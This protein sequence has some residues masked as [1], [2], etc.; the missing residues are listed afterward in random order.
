MCIGSAEER[1]RLT[2]IYGLVESW[3]VS[4]VTSMRGLFEN[5]WW[6][7]EDIWAWNT[8]AVVDRCL[9][10]MWRSYGVLLAMD[11][12]WWRSSQSTMNGV[13]FSGKLMGIHHPSVWE[14]L[15]DLLGNLDLH[16]QNSSAFQELELQMPRQKQKPRLLHMAHTW[17]TNEPANCIYFGIK[18]QKLLSR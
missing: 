16:M 17:A 3:D 5:N 14:R 2:S 12:W 11:T 15:P 8:S 10:W 6:F 7:N 13:F 9:T 4:Q 1:T 18:P